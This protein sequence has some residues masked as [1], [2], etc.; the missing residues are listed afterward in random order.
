VCRA[1]DRG[2]IPDVSMTNVEVF[3]GLLIAAIPLVGLARRW[4]VPYPIVLVAGGLVLGFVPGLPP[5][6]LDPDLVLLIFLPPLLYWESITAPTDEMLSNAQA[7]WPLA[8]GLVI[9]T[10][11]GVAAIAHAIV[12]QMGWA[13]AFVLGAIVAPTDELAAVPIADRLGVPRHVVA[14]IEGESLL[15]DAASLVI[16]VMAVAAVVSGTFSWARAPLAFVTAAI[17]A[18]AIGLVVAL[19]ALAAWRQFRDTPTQTVIS[20]LV[21][22]VAYVPAQALHVSGVLAVVTAGVFINRHTPLVITPSARLQVVGWWETTVFLANTVIFIL[23][24]LSLHSVV[25]SAREHH[26]G[27]REL[28]LTAL[29]VNAGLIAI[30][31]GWLGVQSAILRARGAFPPGDETWKHYVVIGAAG[32]RGAVS[33]A[34]ALAIPMTV[35]HGGK[36]PERELIIFVSFSVIAVSLLGG[37]LTLPALLNALH[38]RGDDTEQAEVVRALRAANEAALRRLA[39]LEQ[40]GR[41]DPDLARELRERYEERLK[42]FERGTPANDRETLARFAVE[43]E[44]IDAQRKTLVELRRRGEIENRVLRRLQLTLDIAET[45]LE[46]FVADAED[47]SEE[48]SELATSPPEASLPEARRR[49]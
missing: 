5:I 12:P 26:H 38:M 25:L 17:G 6:A 15:N 29:A 49:T 36:F 23:L 10:T 34:A 19:L 13:A 44:L 48:E 43:R 47:I 37:G 46:R 7:I 32:L 4:H 8:V 35:P 33:L 11:A 9:A 18:F 39:E 45:E 28:L 16:Y 3:V 30:R 27:W 42:R 2:T 14:I 21:P 24:G 22:F 40:E 1:E 20:V 41:V 31:F